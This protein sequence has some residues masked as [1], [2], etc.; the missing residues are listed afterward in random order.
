MDLVTLNKT[1]V[2]VE[3]K[4]KPVIAVAME[5][6]KIADYPEEVRNIN[7]LTLL[8]WLLN[9]LGVNG[10]DKTEHHT[11]L[12]KLINE[13]YFRFTYQEI[14]LAFEYYIQGK[15]SE[16]GKPMLVTQQLNGVVFGK[17]MSQ[18]EALKKSNEMD[19]YRAKLK[20]QSQ[21]SKEISQQEKDEIVRNG[22][23]NCF[24]DW[25]K[26]KKIEPGYLWLYD[27]LDELGLLSFSPQ[28]KKQR[29]LDA[30]DY[31]QKRSTVEPDKYKRNQIKEALKNIYS[32]PI[33]NKAKRLLVGDYF[34]SILSEFKHIKDF[35]YK[36]Q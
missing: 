7:T 12:H 19:A 15:Y 16:N 5:N 35:L 20:Q 10:E 29:M 9:V 24:N 1:V 11:T 31:L 21:S 23:I 36:K 18:Y 2:K 14:K 27:H 17:V 25:L 26:T 33:V 6:P 3:M 30:K 28:E 4:N 8:E 22:V 13:A 34:Q 32:E